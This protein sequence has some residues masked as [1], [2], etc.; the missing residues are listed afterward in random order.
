MTVKVITDISICEQIWQRHH[1]DVGLFDDW[2]VRARL[3]AL[4]DITPCFLEDQKTGTVLPLGVRSGELTFFGG[5]YYCE[6]NDFIGPVG[7]EQSLLTHLERDTRPFRLLSWRADPMQHLNERQ[8]AWDV[9]FNQAWTF[10]PPSSF[11]IYQAGFSASRQKDNRYLLRRFVNLERMNTW[12]DADAAWTVI[13]RY[14]DYTAEV[15]RARERS[16]IYD[17][18]PYREVVQTLIKIAV[19][20]G[21]LRTIE[22]VDDRAESVRHQDVAL[23]VLIEVP[24]SGK[25]VY[26]LNLYRARPNAASNAVQIGLIQYCIEQGVK[27]DAMRGAFS[28]KSRYGLSPQP[29]YALVRDPNWTIR[30]QTDLDEQALLNLYGRDFGSPEGRSG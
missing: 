27:L 17:S 10:D 6:Y 14:M 23:G 11:E 19:A 29:C 4:A 20:K 15:F 7:G 24:G 25:A 28:L 12:H 16:C 5:D 30:P 22:I 2:S 26:L 1:Q 13:D 21:W 18:R 3:A 8:S 9:P